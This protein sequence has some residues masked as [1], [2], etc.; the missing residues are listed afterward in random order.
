MGK[1]NKPRNSRKSEGNLP[2]LARGSDLLDKMSEISPAKNACGVN[3]PE[4]DENSVY[5]SNTPIRSVCSDE[6]SVNNAEE[7]PTSDS[8]SPCGVEPECEEISSEL[9][10]IDP[11][12]DEMLDDFDQG[13]TPNA[14]KHI[15]IS[16]KDLEILIDRKVNTLVDRKMSLLAKEVNQ[17][18]KD[19]VSLNQQIVRLK[20]DNIIKLKAT[21]DTVID[22]C[23]KVV[24]T[25]RTDITNLVST[26]AAVERSQDFVSKQF[27]QFTLNQTALI[28]NNKEHKDIMVKLT[29]RANGSEDQ[30]R[31]YN[32]LF[33]NM[34][35]ADGF[36]DCEKLVKARLQKLLPDNEEEIYFDRV[37]RLGKKDFS[38]DQNRKIRPV[39]AKFTYYKQK[40]I[41]LKGVR[42]L[43]ANGNNTVKHGVGEDFC[44]ATGQLRKK[45]IEKLD[46]AK[47]K[48][49]Q[50][51]GGNLNY[52]TLVMRFEVGDKNLYRRR[53]L[54][55]IEKYPHSW[56]NLKMITE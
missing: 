29:E 37:H 32:L 8:E 48:N 14:D 3:I 46:E 47:V 56:Y 18:K 45:L 43:N 28:N 22:M 40:E 16:V 23:T 13:L 51:K 39:I 21:S 5:V 2:D 15:T 31:R 42:A 49:K 52:K 41:V 33:Y 30:S 9:N 4:I 1:K 25:Q 55:D 26:V 11:Q 44:R 19:N 36:E 35:E 53:T 6:T 20:E 38:N 50:V 12:N 17:L 24:N 10:G 34:P 54:E 7:A 27:D